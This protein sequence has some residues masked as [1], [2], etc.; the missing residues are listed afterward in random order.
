MHVEV[1]EQVEGQ[2]VVQ[3]EERAVVRAEGQAEV[4]AEVQLAV[5]HLPHH[6]IPACAKAAL[7]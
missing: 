3:A 2:A 1:G 7:A 5:L 6:P 4:Q